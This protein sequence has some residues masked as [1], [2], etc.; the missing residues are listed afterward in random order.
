MGKLGVLEK[1]QS[2]FIEFARANTISYGDAT[3]GLP[4][5]SGS[6]EVL[7]SSHMLEHLD[8]EEVGMFLEEAKRLLRPRGDHQTGYS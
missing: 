6:V 5:D 1:A 7:Y 3:R 2:D 4:V 8:H